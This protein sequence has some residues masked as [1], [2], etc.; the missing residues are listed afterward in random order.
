MFL[1]LASSVIHYGREENPVP[2]HRLARGKKREKKKKSKN[3]ETSCRRAFLLTCT[4]GGEGGKK[5][6]DEAS[7]HR[8]PRKEKEGDL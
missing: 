2:D 6:M 3:Q 1:F 7:A 8:H 4:P 5:R